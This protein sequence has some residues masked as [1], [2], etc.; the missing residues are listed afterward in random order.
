ME[1]SELG[2]TER[3]EIS[4]LNHKK[5][6]KWRRLTY[7]ILGLFSHVDG[8]IETLNELVWVT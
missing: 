4:K 7:E 6:Q 1:K 3:A 8:V 5:F 2:N